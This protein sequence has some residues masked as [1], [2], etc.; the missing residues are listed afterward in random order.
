[1]QAAISEKD[2]IRMK[3]GSECIIA[4]YKYCKY[5]YRVYQLQ[6]NFPEYFDPSQTDWF[7]KLMKVKGILDRTTCKRRIEEKCKMRLAERRKMITK[8]GKS[9]R[10]VADAMNANHYA[11]EAIIRHQA[12]AKTALKEMLANLTAKEENRLSNLAGIERARVLALEVAEGDLREYIRLNYV[13][14]EA[15]LKVLYYEVDIRALALLETRADITIQKDD[16][17]A[18]R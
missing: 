8:D 17:E 18:N 6:D 14:V 1:M 2:F 7:R 11:L 13:P 4:L 12:R 5:I 3:N 9:Y 10:T 16:N 15:K